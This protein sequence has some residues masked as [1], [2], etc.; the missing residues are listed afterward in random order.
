MIESF[1]ENNDGSSSVIDIVLE[2]INILKILFIEDD[3]VNESQYALTEGNPSHTMTETLKEIIVKA[4]EKIINI[5]EKIKEFIKKVERFITTK[6][7]NLLKIKHVKV[8]HLFFKDV[9]DVLSTCDKISINKVNSML[10]NLRGIYNISEVSKINTECTDILHKISSVKETDAYKRIE[11]NQ[12]DFD[13]SKLITV[14]YVGLAIH[15]VKLKSELASLG[16]NIQILDK[17]YKKSNPDSSFSK[18][19]RLNISATMLNINLINIKLLVLG[20]LP[21]KDNSVIHVK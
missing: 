14:T 8:N 13:Q 17:L 2:S 20:R 11:E 5:I 3:I 9:Q 4:K 21:Q 10:M 18:L 1:I 7:V 12:Y 6:L 19:L 15:E 16:N